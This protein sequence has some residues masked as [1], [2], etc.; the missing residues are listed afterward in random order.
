ME[1]RKWEFLSFVPIEYCGPGSAMLTLT[2][3]VAIPA[4]AARR[5]YGEFIMEEPRDDEPPRVEY[6][7]VHG[8]FRI[9]YTKTGACVCFSDG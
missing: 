6:I 5:G 4:K 1:P 7:Y 9:A 8:P 2:R 3:D